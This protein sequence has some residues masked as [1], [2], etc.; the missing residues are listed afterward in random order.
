M[1]IRRQKKTTGGNNMR[2]KS[3][4]EI[5]CT[6]RCRPR[7]TRKTYTLTDANWAHRIF[8]LKSS[9]PKFFAHFRAPLERSATLQTASPIENFPIS[10]C[11]APACL[12]VI[13]LFFVCVV[14]VLVVCSYL[15]VPF[16]L[17]PCG[18]LLCCAGLS[19]RCYPYKCWVLVYAVVLFCANVVRFVQ[20]NT[21]SVL[22]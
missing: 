6:R 17:L 13:R 15:C 2:R 11:Y 18:R 4:I 5:K 3:F 22:S 21:K 8:Q 19:A 1:T 9:R 16:V 14:C 7:C 10:P 12:F 20:H